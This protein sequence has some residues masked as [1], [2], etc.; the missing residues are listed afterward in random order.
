MLDFEPTSQNDRSTDCGKETDYVML[1]IDAAQG[2]QAAAEF[3]QKK[4]GDSVKDSYGHVLPLKYTGEAKSTWQPWPPGCF[5]GSEGIKFNANLNSGDKSSYHNNVCMKNPNPPSTSTVTDTTRTTTTRY[6]PCHMALFPGREPTVH[7][8]TYDGVRHICTATSSGGSASKDTRAD[9]CGMRE[10]YCCN[11][12]SASQGCSGSGEDFKCNNIP[13]VLGCRNEYTTE[14]GKKMGE[15]CSTNQGTKEFCFGAGYRFM[16]CPVEDD[17]EGS[18]STEAPETTT[19]ADATT[20]TAADSTSGSSTLMYA[21]LYRSRHECASH[22][23][24]HT[25]GV[26]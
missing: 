2:C 14:D 1:T 17:G 9:N 23:R 16:C 25:Y 22:V 11:F 15:M 3:L 4:Y 8:K 18:D 12:F 19:D 5:A 21:R 7:K 6:L 20:T 13:N 10:D 26:L 24:V